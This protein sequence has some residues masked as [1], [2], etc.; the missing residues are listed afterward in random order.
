MTIQYLDWGLLVVFRGFVLPDILNICI[1]AWSSSSWFCCTKKV[2][3]SDQCLCFTQNAHDSVS[4]YEEVTWLRVIMGVLKSHLTAGSKWSCLTVPGLNSKSS[5]KTGLNVLRFLF[6]TQNSMGVHTEVKNL[7]LQ[8]CGYEQDH[9]ISAFKAENPSHPHAQTPVCMWSPH[10][11]RGGQITEQRFGKTH[12]WGTVERQILALSRPSVSKLVNTSLV[13]NIAV[14]LFHS[15]FYQLF[16]PAAVHL[17]RRDV[18]K[19]S[20]H[21]MNI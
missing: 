12:F 14:V 18:T 10:T 16:V 4:L 9:R 21:S 5:S 13:W 2:K 6:L 19:C 8:L 1:S 7:T 15:V 3:G 11:P 17:K 20:P